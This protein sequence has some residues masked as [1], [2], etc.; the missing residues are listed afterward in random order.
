[1]LA[2]ALPRSPSPASVDWNLDFGKT[3]WC[4]GVDRC[5]DL[6][7][8]DLDKPPPALAKYHNR[9]LPTGQVLLIAK[10]SIRGDQDIESGGFGCVQQLAVS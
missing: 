4:R 2:R 3:T 6:R 8:P 9:E 10:V 1:M 5:G 7:K